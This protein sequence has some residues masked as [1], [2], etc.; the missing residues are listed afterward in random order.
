MLN[1]PSLFDFKSIWGYMLEYPVAWHEA[2]RIQPPER[3][4]RAVQLWRRNRNGEI[5]VILSIPRRR[6]PMKKPVLLRLLVWFIVFFTLFLLSGCVST[7]TVRGSEWEPWAGEMTGMVEADLKMFFSRSEQEQN[8]Y[9]IE[10]NF[11]GDIKNYQGGTGSGKMR[12]KIKGRVKDGICDIDIWGTAVV[13]EGTVTI[14]GKMIGT[15]SK[16]QAFGTW[17]IVARDDERYEVSGEWR[18]EKAAS[19]SQ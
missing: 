14:N 12:A 19:E 3:P 4:L 9:L 2:A 5:F 8:V 11:E 7:Q 15:L 18:A 1:H 6:L 13:D 10:G 17:E 16:T